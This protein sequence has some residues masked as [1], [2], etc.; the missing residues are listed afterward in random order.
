MKA[1]DL[2]IIIFSMNRA[3]QL[4]AFLRSMYVMFSEVRDVKTTVLYRTTTK[5]FEDGYSLVQQ[6]FKNINYYRETSIKDDLRYLVGLNNKKYVVFF[7]D[8]DIWKHPFSL[9]FKEVEEFSVNDNIAT[10]SLRM[11]PF[12]SKCHPMGNLDT[13]PAKFIGQLHTWDWTT[14]GLKGD[15]NYPLSVDGHVFRSELILNYIETTGF[16]NVTEFEGYI[17]NKPPKHLPLMLC[18][19]DSPIF[20][21]PMNR[22]SLVSQ[23]INMNITKEYLNERFLSGDRIDTESYAG[24]RNISP[25]QEVEIKWK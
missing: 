3:C 14:P 9:N 20:N 16:S 2:H 10:L 23:N 6:N 4:E 22:A 13:P 1:E 11:S 19:D 25:H 18:C 17:A 24:F 8:D 12:I 21:I 5:E 7:C 15:W